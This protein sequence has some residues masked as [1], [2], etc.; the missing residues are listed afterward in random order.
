LTTARMREWSKFTDE[1]VMEF[2]SVHGWHRM[3]GPMM[4]RS[5][6]EEEFEKMLARIPLH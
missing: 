4:A 5:L 1:H 6:N 2:L 3:I